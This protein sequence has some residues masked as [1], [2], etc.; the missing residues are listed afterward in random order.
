M[1]LSPLVL[2]A[3]S[4][5]FVATAGAA[6]L[7]VAASLGVATCWAACGTA[8][9]YAGRRT[10]SVSVNVTRIVLGWGLLTLLH[11]GLVGGVWPAGVAVTQ[12]WILLASG[13]VGLA[14]GDIFLFHCLVHL[15]PRIG[16]LLMALAPAMTALLAWPMLGETL[17]LREIAGI[18]V[19]T[20]GVIAVILDR[21]D[22]EAWVRPVGHEQN[23]RIW[24]LVCGALAALGQAGGLVLSKLGMDNGDGTELNA[25]SAT[26]VRMPAGVLGTVLFGLCV[27]QRGAF[28][29]L[30]RD[31][32]AVAVTLFGTVTGPV[33]GIWLSLVA[34]QYTSP[35]I[36]A[37]LMGVTPILMIPV[38]RIAYGA[39]PG[40]LGVGGTILAVAGGGLLAL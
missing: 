13:L 7:G 34:L 38:S 37:T 8:F 15:G 17:E 29:R 21:G 12:V 19:V 3:G 25:L 36:A 23:S 33:L 5:A 14:A 6:T 31:R 24:P 11:L 10:D 16:S 9:A 27:A 1:T 18:A 35:A 32:V 39:R 22:R 30:A 2:V 26:V 28:M 40:S 4:T 20:L